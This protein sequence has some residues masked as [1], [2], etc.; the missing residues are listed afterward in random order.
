M[1][2]ESEP[3]PRRYTEAQAEWA[4]VNL[5]PK[6]RGKG[7]QVKAGPLDDDERRE[8]AALLGLK[9]DDPYLLGQSQGKE[10]DRG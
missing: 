8:L 4:G 6:R 7:R 10:D 2:T 9:G 3:E 1:R 5:D